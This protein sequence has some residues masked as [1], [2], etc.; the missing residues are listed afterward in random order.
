MWRA[1]S[2]R[3]SRH[4]AALTILEVVIGDQPGPLRSLRLASTG[5]RATPDHDPH[6]DGGA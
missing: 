6:G 2:V 1:Y 3:S 5:A 4:G